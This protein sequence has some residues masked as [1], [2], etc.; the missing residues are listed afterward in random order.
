M[1]AP[2][3]GIE[4]VG[5]DP[6]RVERA[7]AVLRGGLGQGFITREGF[8]A[9]AAPRRARPFRAALAATDGAT[10]AVVGALTIEIPGARALRESFLGGYEQ[11]RADAEIADLRP[12]RTG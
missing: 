4:A 8:M 11:A 3:I 5:A 6:A 9:Y 10:G 2:D 12:G 7:L 1:A